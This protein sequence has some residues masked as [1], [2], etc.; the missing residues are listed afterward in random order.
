MNLK[1][2][3]P[4]LSINLFRN[5]A[6]GMDA[7]SFALSSGSF[8]KI[9]ANT[10]SV[11]ARDELY[12]LDV[13]CCEVDFVGTSEVYLLEEFSNQPYQ[14]FSITIEY[15]SNPLLVGFQLA[16]AKKP[17]IILSCGSL[18]HALSLY[19]IGTRAVDKEYAYDSLD[20]YLHL[21]AEFKPR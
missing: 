2:E 17:P 19:G 7:A 9:T 5:H 1:I 8:F 10:K 3:T 18:A 21:I 12:F 14:I 16:F 4:I 6:G 15:E 20:C 13:E 11:A